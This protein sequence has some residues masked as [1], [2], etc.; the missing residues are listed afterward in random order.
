MPT[1]LPAVAVT[2]ADPREVAVAKPRESAALLIDATEL[3]VLHVTNDLVRF[4]VVLSEYSPMAVNC[5]V[6]PKARLELCGATTIDCRVALVTVN[7]VDA[8]ILP[9]VAVIVLLP[10]ATEVAK[11]REPPALLT[12]AT[13]ELEELQV[14]NAVMSCVLLSEYA[15]VAVKGFVV[16]SAM[17]GLLGV[18]VID[19]SVAAVTVNAVDPV[20]LPS[21]AVMLLLPAVTML[22]HP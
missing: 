17:L 12:T 7:T 1:I 15:P 19:T 5:T 11:P 8:E 22:A 16:P 10:L 3:E 6:A 4:C 13:A 2:I 20:I 9:Q 21:V 14:T 18:I